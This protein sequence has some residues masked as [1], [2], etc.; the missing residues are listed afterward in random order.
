MHPTHD[1]TREFTEALLSTGLGLVDSLS[2]LLEGLPEDAFPGEE[3][4]AVLV[5][6]LV[7]TLRPVTKAA[8]ERTVR[9]A[10]ALLAAAHERFLMDLHKAAELAAD[11]PG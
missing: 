7:G 9:E 6:M 11:R 3:P 1:T 2:T 10:T 5:E 8:G 4:A